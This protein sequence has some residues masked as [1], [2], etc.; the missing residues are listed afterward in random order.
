MAVP[1]VPTYSIAALAA[2]HT[3]FKDLIDA[4]SGAGLAK[5]RNSAGTLLASITMADP[6]GAVSSGTGQLS[7]TL[8]LLVNAGATGTAAYAELCDSAGLV[9]L[10]LPCAVGAAAVSGFFVLQTLALVAGA[11][12]QVL[13][14]TIG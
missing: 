11:P 14:A 12:V 7:L 9:H 2:A 13:S 5:I 6:C 10:A 3:A 1:T 8:P 4:G